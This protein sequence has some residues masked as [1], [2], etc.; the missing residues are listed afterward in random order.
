MQSSDNMSIEGKFRYALEMIINNYEIY[1]N[2]TGVVT[3]EYLEAV[4][5]LRYGLSMTATV[6]SE[7]YQNDTYY[8]LLQHEDLNQLFNLVES[9][10]LNGYCTQPHEFITKY[11]VRRFGMQ[12]MKKLVENPAFEWLILP[13]LKPRKK[14]RVTID[15]MELITCLFQKNTTIDPFV[16]YDKNYKDIREAVALSL[17]GSD[18]TELQIVLKV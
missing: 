4:A 15:Y 6:I 17:C 7:C 16:L 9:L 12:F 5:S 10:C 11:I 14:V 3:L 8:D 2:F 18:V 13:H 1:Q